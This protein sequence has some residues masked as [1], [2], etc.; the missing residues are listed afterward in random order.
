MIS[1]VCQAQQLDA[2]SLVFNK[3]S[4]RVTFLSDSIYIDSSNPQKSII[5]FGSITENNKWLSN[6]KV[7]I[8]AYQSIKLVD[9]QDQLFYGVAF[10]FFFFGILKI[11]FAKYFQNLIRVFFN[12][13]LRQIQLK[14][15]LLQ[16]KLPSLLF[17]LFFIIVGGAYI[18]LL[19]LKY[20]KIAIYDYQFFYYG[21]AA[22]ML[23][24]I[25]KLIIIQFLGWISGFK[26]EAE[27]YS[28]MVFLI[29][30][31]L[32][33]AL[34]PLIAIIAFASKPLS[35][36]TLVGSLILIVFLFLLRYLRIFGS[37]QQ[38]LKISKFHFILFVFSIEIL[39]IM[40]IYQLVNNFIDKSL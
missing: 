18:Y 22:V 23:I 29:N 16:D 20:K 14:D 2:D 13:S 25:T 5:K 11:S 35:H 10:L 31:M 37:I 1:S 24:Y 30:K 34:L 38:S 36:Y 19:M 17:N 26:K 12:T 15:Q 28:F 27:I 33:V 32:A 3:D 9:K 39:P 6:A 40:L 8:P 4:S 7:A 21:M